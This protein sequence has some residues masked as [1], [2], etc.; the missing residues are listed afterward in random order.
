MCT[1][2]S[3]HFKDRINP[4]KQTLST[5]STVKSGAR[6]TTL[7]LFLVR[8]RLIP[9]SRYCY[10]QDINRSGAI[11]VNISLAPRLLKTS[12]NHIVWFGSKR[13]RLYYINK[14]LQ[15]QNTTTTEAFCYTS[16]KDKQEELN[17]K[18][19][20]KSGRQQQVISKPSKSRPFAR[21]ARQELSFSAYGIVERLRRRKA[22]R[23]CQVE[24]ARFAPSRSCKKDGKNALLI[25]PINFKRESL[26]KPYA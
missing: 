18:L 23:R 3:R 7:L 17:R 16:L 1:A 19:N 21:K 20:F 11:V 24:W 12:L 2:L 26:S 10:W 6:Q 22:R 9:I 13:N 5:T 25:E 8:S 15:V 4:S 14:W